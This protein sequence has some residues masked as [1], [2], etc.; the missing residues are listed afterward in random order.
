MLLVVN[1]ECFFILKLL[2]QHACSAIWCLL[3]AVDVE[4]LMLF[5]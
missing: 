4:F 1:V 5:C 2:L 3:L